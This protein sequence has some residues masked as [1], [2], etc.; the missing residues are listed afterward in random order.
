MHEYGLLYRRRRD[1]SDE[2]G[3]SGPSA[4]AGV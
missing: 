3:G 4:M 1:D 2:E